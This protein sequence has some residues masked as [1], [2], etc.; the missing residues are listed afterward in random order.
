MREE[1]ARLVVWFYGSQDAC[2]WKVRVKT[3][4]LGFSNFTVH[5]NDQRVC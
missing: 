1:E 3:L 4:L 5:Q 2:Q